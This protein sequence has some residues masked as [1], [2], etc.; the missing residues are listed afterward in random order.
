MVINKK[1]Q[2]RNLLQI[3]DTKN[4]L[5]QFCENNKTQII[6]EIIKL[7]AEYKSFLNSLEYHPTF[8]TQDKIKNINNYIGKQNFQLKND[9]K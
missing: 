7:E 4:Q 3:N 2:T 9:E 8:I 5:K 1:Q 6:E